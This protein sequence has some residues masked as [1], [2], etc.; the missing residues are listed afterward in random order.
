MHPHAALWKLHC[1]HYSTPLFSL[2][3]ERRACAA[4]FSSRRGVARAGVAADEFFAAH[5]WPLQVSSAAARNALIGFPS[6][7]EAAAEFTVFV[8]VIALE[9]APAASGLRRVGLSSTPRTREAKV[10]EQMVSAA[11]AASGDT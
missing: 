10:R 2:S 3:N 1:A 6:H 9:T 11:S 4:S 7:V 5:A 8:A